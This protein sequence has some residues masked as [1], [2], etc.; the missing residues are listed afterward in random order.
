M[1]QTLITLK[2][3]NGMQVVV[4]DFGAR[5]CSI[6]F[7]TCHGPKEML[8]HYQDESQFVDDPFY[9]GAICGR[10][11][12]RIGRGRFGY[13]GQIYQYSQN[14]GEHCLHGGEQSIDKRFWQITEQ[15]PSSV[16]LT[17]S[18]PDGDNGF[19]GNVNI[20]VTYR[21]FE[22]NKL[23]IEICAN[24]DKTTP[25]NF[26]NH[27]YFN[28]AERSVSALELCIDAELVLEKDAG[29][30]PT[31]K[32]LKV[33]ESEST[34]LRFDFREP[35]SLQQT[36]D[37]DHY[38]VFYKAPRGMRLVAQL[39]S[40][41]NGVRLSV[42]SDQNGLQCY[43]GGFLSAPFS[44][45]SGVCLELH[46]YPDALNHEQFDSILVQPEQQYKNTMI[47]SFTELD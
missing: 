35:K 3:S 43:M 45:Y 42:F 46:N 34:A 27:A 29:N 36:R 41:N 40:K 2:N 37:L 17:L 13:D 6:I 44:P 15:L 23:E 9:V 11:S 47:L 26:T 25:L 20:Q 12:N 28:L 33:D 24:T 10:V 1:K 32:L 30:I 18:S 7:S 4:S 21:L 16:T 22:D 19:A 8:M 5:L 38:Y 39:V 31:G 14:E